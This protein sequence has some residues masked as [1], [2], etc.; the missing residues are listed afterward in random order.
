MSIGSFIEHGTRRLHFYR[1]QSGSGDD[2]K[3]KCVEESC[4]E[5]LANVGIPKGLSCQVLKW[6]PGRPIQDLISRNFLELL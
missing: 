5:I 1:E 3:R 4:R 2:D 6:L